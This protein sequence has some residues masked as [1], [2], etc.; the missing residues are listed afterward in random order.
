MNVLAASQSPDSFWRLFCLYFSK[1]VTCSEVKIFP[2]VAKCVLLRS[3]QY[4]IVYCYCYSFFKLCAQ[5]LLSPSTAIHSQS[6]CNQTCR[7][8]AGQTIDSSI[9]FISE[10][11]KLRP[12]FCAVCGLS[13]AQLIRPS[14][15]LS[16]RRS[17]WPAGLCS[18][19]P[20][21]TP[22]PSLPWSW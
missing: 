2:C 4:F 17:V 19:T 7:P 18:E 9:S 11:R 1:T 6:F 16:P 22:C 8:P 21:T 12:S 20:P 14:L 13:V 5:A 10:T 3:Y 15:C